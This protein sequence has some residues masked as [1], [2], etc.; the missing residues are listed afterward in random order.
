MYV[1]RDALSLPLTE[2]ILKTL[3][4]V[5]VDII[6]RP[7]EAVEE[8]RMVPDPIAT[9]KKLLLVMKPK[10]RL[11]KPCPCTPR[12]IGCGYRIIN[13]DLNCPLDCTYCILQLYMDH[14]VITVHADTGAL[15]HELDAYLHQNRSRPLRIGTG[16]LGD[17]LA[18]DHITG[19]SAEF[20]RYFASHPGVLFE[21]KT[22]TANIGNLLRR[23]PP[24]NVVIAWSLNTPAIARSEE[25]GAPPVEERIEAAHVL[26][27]AGYRVAFHF[28]PLILYPGWERDYPALITRLMTR[29]SRERIAWIS[30]GSLRFPPD[31][32]S[33]IRKRFRRTEIIAQEF[34]SGRDGKLRYPKPLRLRL[35]GRIAA[36]LRKEA[37][38]VPVYLCMESED[39]WE[40]LLRIK[41][42][43]KRDVEKRL[44]LPLR[45]RR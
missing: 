6:S 11:I 24:K 9:G 34:I 8:A 26:S 21:M 23:K 1:V 13:A 12:Y 10:G 7:E 32:K 18:L 16:E 5:P 40:A 41:P 15:F 22:K 27:R 25:T 36:S 4:P 43:G 20:L 31:L 30:L 19:R 38:E 39:V 29:V 33:I 2:K 35:F 14:P 44:V 42:R 28:D 37:G 17:S 45:S 3:S